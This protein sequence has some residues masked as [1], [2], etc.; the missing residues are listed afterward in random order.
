MVVVKKGRLLFGFVWYWGG[1]VEDYGF[2]VVIFLFLFRI[3]D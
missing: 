1:E 3:W 2:I